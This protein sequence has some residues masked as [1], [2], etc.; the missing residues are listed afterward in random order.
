MQILGDASIDTLPPSATHE[1]LRIAR[2]HALRILDSKPDTAIDAL[3]T[4]ASQI[5]GVPIALVS[6][7]DRERQWIKANH[8]L[9]GVTETP[10]DVS[11]CTH[12]ILSDE[13]LEVPDATLDGRF[14]DNPLV[15]GALN[16]QFYAGAP[17]CLSDGFRIG[18]LCVIDHQ[19]RRL[20]VAQGET[21]RSLA[22]AA[23]SIIE[24]QTAFIDLAV[25]EARF[26]TLA[27]CSPLGIYYADPEGNF[28]YANRTWQQ[29]YGLSES[30]AHSKGWTA[31]LH[32][33]DREMV[34]KAWQ[35]AAHSKSD[36][37]MRFRIRH[38]DGDERH[39]CSR[40]G[41]VFDSKNQA[42]ACVGSVEDIT[43]QVITKQHLIREGE[44]LRSI[45]DGTNVGTWEWNVQSDALSVNAR[46]AEMIGYSL[47]ELTPLSVESWAQRT[48]PDDLQQVLDRVNRHLSGELLDLDCDI[49]MRHKSGHWVYIHA[50]GRIAS[51]DADGKPLM[52]MGTHTDISARIANER[53]LR[54]SHRV[55][56]RTGAIASIGGWSIDIGSGEIQWSDETCRV[57]D[58]APGT[59]TTLE[60]TLQ[61]YA[62]ESRACITAALEKS[63]VDG[64]PWD[65]EVHLV[66]AKGR[67]IWTRISGEV[68]FEHGQPV[69]F[70]GA[71][72][73]ISRR[74]EAE[75]ALAESRELLEVTLNSIG[76]AVLT[77]DVDGRVTW[78]NPVAEKMTGWTKMAASGES[79]QKVFNILHEETRVVVENPIFLCMAEGRTVS[80]AD[81]TVLVARDNVELGIQDSAAPIRDQSGK[82]LGAVLVFHDVSDKRRLSKEMEYR[83]TH[84]SLTGLINRS[85]FEQR[86]TRVFGHAKTGKST[87]ALMYIDLDQFKIVNDSCGH[88]VGDQLLKQVSE[89]LAV[90][91]R[92]RD[93]L[94]RLGGDEF[95]VILEHCTVEQAARVAQ[96][97]CDDM[98][99]FRFI[100]DGKRYRVGASIGLVPITI[101]SS[102]EASVLKAADSACFAAKDSGRNR[103]HTWLDTDTTMLERK[104]EMRWANRIERAIDDDKFVLYSQQIAPLSHAATRAHCEILVRMRGPGDTIIPPGAFL[105]AAERYHLASR[106]DRWVVSHVF[107]IMNS[108]SADF[109][110]IDTV[111]I[112][113]SGQS[114]GDQVFHRFISAMILG[115]QFDVGKLCFEVT[116]TAVITNIDH[117]RKF[118][119][120]I[121]DLGIRVALDDFGAGASSF[122]YLKS[123]PVNYLKIDG[124][125][126]KNILD[127]PFD[128]ATVRCF[129][130]VA[131]VVGI[132]TIAEFVE[133]A[134]V[135]NKISELGVDFA[136]GYLI[137]RPEPLEEF[138]RNTSVLA[139]PDF[140]HVRQ[141]HSS[142][143]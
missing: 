18:T 91:V 21:L 84:D 42:V 135:L 82:V 104:G 36:F 59:R 19:P 140:S 40:A 10:R 80:L 37:E 105:P 109:D 73:D 69:R 99:A 137:H 134:E 64:T 113:L 71:L 101:D 122:G 100:H 31:T 143:A 9:P 123:L 67:R 116:E 58:V 121:R 12:A 27:N 120:E 87:N 110:S 11:F 103:V 39:V 45:L 16:I 54:D 72:Q 119:S 85:E 23:A 115:A 5:C 29:I 30:E 38:A 108:H 22:K 43:P 62:Q 65:L 127:N 53:A 8:G 66:T 129:V 75:R 70:V 117:A 142:A 20:S 76:D 28:T 139:L 131:R 14:C 126:I 132:E 89:L 90:C 124:Q 86:L 60:E 78:M 77:T 4:A 26:R 32:P 98:N 141:L 94:A 2:L 56:E 97:I 128:I 114:I 7:V 68:E 118:I 83:A 79:V 35:V 50:R 138:L 33:D 88:N 81:R 63:L 51:R 13:V 44:R 34:I 55:L 25:S 6:L 46:W 112:N 48:H 41:Y 92:K 1:D 61:S 74:Y 125:F 95:G 133:S 111:T 49:R 57:M 130:E 15:T 93:T 102:S 17:I 106:L 136:Q 47:A 3:V 96:K 107:E 52:M 24:G